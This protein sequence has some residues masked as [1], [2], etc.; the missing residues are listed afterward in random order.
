[1]KTILRQV[2]EHITFIYQMVN[3]RENYNFF[4]KIMAITNVIA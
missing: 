3:N 1:M 4:T 2:Q